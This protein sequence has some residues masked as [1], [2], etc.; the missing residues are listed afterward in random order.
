[1]PRARNTD[2][3]T[4]HEAAA[5]VR[6]LTETQAVILDLFEFKTSLMTDNKLIGWYQWAVA[7]LDAPE[8]SESGIRS[9]RAELVR[10]GELEDSGNRE[11]L[12]SGRY[13]IVW[14]KTR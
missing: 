10:A 14:T 11:K 4:S 3:Q 8:A 6:N 13:A 12:K 7:N 9:R 5:S 1:M 2:P